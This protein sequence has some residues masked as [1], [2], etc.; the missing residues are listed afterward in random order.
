MDAD[1]VSWDHGGRAAVLGGSG[2]PSSLRLRLRGSLQ[3]SIAQ[4]GQQIHPADPLQ[5]LQ[6]CASWSAL[7]R[8]E[9]GIDALPTLKGMSKR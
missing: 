5:P 4:V 2:E 8:R 6:L 3:P 7:G 9:R 1:T